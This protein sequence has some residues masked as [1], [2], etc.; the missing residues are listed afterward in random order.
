MVCIREVCGMHGYVAGLIG[1]GDT[2]VVAVLYCSR[3]SVSAHALATI[4]SVGLLG[5]H[6][7]TD[8]ASAKD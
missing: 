8:C 1:C 6:M 3:K 4:S 5:I 2:A 7:M